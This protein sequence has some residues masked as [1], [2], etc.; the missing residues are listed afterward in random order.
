MKFY[1]RAVFA[2]GFSVSIQAH[3]GSYC[4]PRVSNAEAYSEVELGFPNQPCPFIMEYAEDSRDL[5]GTVYPY[6][7]SGVVRRMIEAHGGLVEGEIPP[8]K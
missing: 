6:V 7:P 8:L 5:T 1:K 2:D 4:Q 3:D